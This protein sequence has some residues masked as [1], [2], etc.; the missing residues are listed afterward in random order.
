MTT[1]LDLTTLDKALT[2]LTQ[3]HHRVADADFMAQQD[4]VVRLGL[5]AG[6]VQHLEFTY[7]VCWKMMRR[8]L[9][10]NQNAQVEGITRRE[11]FRLAAENGL[12]DNVEAW[13]LFHELR[14]NTAHRYDSQLATEALAL[15]ADFMA[16]A[17]ALLAYLNR[18]ND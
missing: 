18:H 2:A 4:D 5:Q 10:T 16:A 8:W 6:L 9:K 12:I 1:A 14:N 3:L 13:M 11:L 17:R 15:M 7:E